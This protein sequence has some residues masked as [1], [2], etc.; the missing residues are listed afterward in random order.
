MKLYATTTSER[1]SKGQGGEW[2]DINITDE[3]QEV[4]AMFKVRSKNDTIGKLYYIDTV[5]RED[6]YVDKHHWLDTILVSDS[7]EIALIHKHRQQ[8]GKK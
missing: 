7:N 5:I 3:N 4:L 8:Q 2:L 1:A 6:V